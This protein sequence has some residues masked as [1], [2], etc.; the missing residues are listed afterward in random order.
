MWKWEPEEFGVYSVR[1]AYNVLTVGDFVQPFK[2]LW[3]SL[4]PKKVLAFAWKLIL[5][6]IPTKLNLLRG[7]ILG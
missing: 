1:S 2:M 6:R 4:A 7:V 5:D 3:K